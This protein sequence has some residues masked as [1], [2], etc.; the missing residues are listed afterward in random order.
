MA[1]TCYCWLDVILKIGQIPSTTKGWKSLYNCAC[2]NNAFNL[3][4]YLQ[5][6]LV[7]SYIPYEYLQKVEIFQ[8]CK[9]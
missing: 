9:I 2:N 3:A 8:Y 7:S 6:F 4:G 5:R 1:E